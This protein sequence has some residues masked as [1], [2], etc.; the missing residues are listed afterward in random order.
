[1][2]FHHEKRGAGGAAPS[3]AA[4]GHPAAAAGWG[5]PGRFGRAG[6][7]TGRPAA[8]AGRGP[9]GPIPGAAGAGD[10]T[11]GPLDEGP[12]SVQ[13][14]RAYKQVVNID[15]ECYSLFLSSN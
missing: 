1:M 3:P 14:Q 9:T 7:P 4:P 6:G 12:F 10:R 13:S 11:R 8:S 2:L 15:R 5:P